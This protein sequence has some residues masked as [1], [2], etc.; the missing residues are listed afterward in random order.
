MIQYNDHMP[1]I[2]PTQALRSAITRPVISVIALWALAFGAAAQDAVTRAGTIAHFAITESSGLAASR[3]YP[4]VIWTHNDSSSNPFL[5]AMRRNGTS[6]RAFPVS[7]AALIDWEDLG[8][9][10]SGNLYVADI[11]ANGMG[12]SHV[13]IHRVREPNPFGR[14]RNVRIERT[15]LVRFPGTREDCEGFF[16][17]RGFGYLVTKQE[18]GGTVTIYGFP[19]AARGRSILL[20]R[21]STVDVPSDV[22]GASISRDAARLA[23]ITDEGPVVYLINGNVAGIRS[24]IGYY[25]PWV[26]TSMEGATFVGDGLLVGAENRDLWLFTDPPFRAQ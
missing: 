24:S 22:T 19:L 17:S 10:S 21:I 7:G 4:G 14:V 5:F 12:R 2:S 15:W 26:E 11:G 8:I 13:A 3:R 18:I 16:V 20:R 23:L 9:D 1:I 6:I 25:R